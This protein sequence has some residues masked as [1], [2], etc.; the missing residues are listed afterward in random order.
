MKDGFGMGGVYHGGGVLKNIFESGELREE[1]VCSILEHTTQHGAIEGKTQS[2]EDSSVILRSVTACD[3]SG[4]HSTDHFSH[5]GRMV[6]IGSGAD[7]A[8]HFPEVR[9]M[10]WSRS[11]SGNRCRR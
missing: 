7:S 6:R 11:G 9:K 2:G 3:N 4:V 5:V 1:V 8:D 10:V